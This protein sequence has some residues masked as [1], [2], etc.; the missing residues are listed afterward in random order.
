[1][2]HGLMPYY[3]YKQRNTLGNLENTGYCKPGCECRYNI[4][5]MDEQQTILAVGGGAVTK[6]WDGSA[7]RL[8]RVFN[9]KYPFEYIDRFDEV[10]RRKQKILDFW[11][12][13]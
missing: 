7:Q 9:Y 13:R 12:V 1:M 6:L 2:P 11:G 4:Y 3:L 5:I 8:E 10:L